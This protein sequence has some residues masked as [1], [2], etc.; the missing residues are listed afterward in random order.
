M[1][2]EVLGD[3]GGR[4]TQILNELEPGKRGEGQKGGRTERGGERWGGN[5][6]GRGR[7]G[8]AHGAF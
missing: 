1:G 3:G 6:K 4:V 8:E 7:E 5:G 2:T